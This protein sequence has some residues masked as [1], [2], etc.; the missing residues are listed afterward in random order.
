[1]DLLNLIALDRDDL[2]VVSAHLQDA[3]LKVADLAYIPAEKRF[4][5]AV[6]RFD[7]E[8]PEADPPRRRR[9]AVHFERVLSAKRAGFDPAA[10]GTVLN[11]LA[12]T[13][14][15]TDA[16]AGIVAIAFSGGAAIRLDVECLE[17]AMRDLGPIWAAGAIPRHEP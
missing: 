17:A 9:T 3:V 5:L 8:E 11:I 13:F 2:E 14:K 6:N 1:M 10:L 4:A 16:P 7:W 15:E 12:V